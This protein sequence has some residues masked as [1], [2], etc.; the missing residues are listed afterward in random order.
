MAKP[1]ALPLMLRS[2][3]PSNEQTPKGLGL[4]ALAPLV[5]SRAIALPSTG[6][7]PFLETWGLP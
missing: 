3:P 5:S 4:N 2:S 6:V 7:F 1:P